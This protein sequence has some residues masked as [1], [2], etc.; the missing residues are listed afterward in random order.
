MGR[1]VRTLVAWCPDWPVTAAGFEADAP[2]A[3]TAA[4][5]VVA[6]SAAAREAG[7]VIGMRR[8][9]AEAS[10]AGLCVVPRDEAREARAFEPVVA[11]V[12]ALAPAVETTRPGLLS[13]ATRGPARYHGGEG[14]LRAA[15]AERM[16]TAVTAACGV[17]TPVHVGIADGPFAAT[18]AARRQMSVPSS[19][20]AKFL[21]PFPVGTLGREGLAEILVRLGIGSL[22]AFAALD[23]DRVS[24]RF[25]PDGA[26]AH[27]L[28]RGLDDRPL[29]ST[30]PPTEL[31]AEAE[32]DPPT[33]RVDVV[34]FA[35]RSL[36]EELA[37]Q[38]AT[39]G[40]ACTMLTIEAETEHGERL[41][42]RWRAEVDLDAPA[43]GERLRWQLEGWLS[44]TA[45]EAPSAGVTRIRFR[46]SETAPALGRQAGFWGGVSAADRRA[47]RA[48]DRLGGM[49]G[50]EAVFTA[51]V[52]GGR[53]PGDRT[54]L[55]AWG[56][57]RPEAAMTAPWPGA[58]PDPP[59][60]LV[61]RPPRRATVTDR[62]GRPV[63]VSARGCLS[64]LPER[65]LVEGRRPSAVVG[66]AGPWLLDERWWDPRVGRRLARFQLLDEDRHA[67]LCFVER[68]EWFVEATYD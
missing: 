9:A 20:T 6:C 32:L 10:C 18:L 53:G 33:E 62:T 4:N 25:G 1:I 51:T 49:L 40:L 48:L 3:V 28:A 39:R 66:W 12:A 67:H 55:V 38:L 22:G 50:P 36:G 30:P 8:R 60:A 11:A 16:A 63:V 56:D 43:M 17:P 54:A 31:V 61:H 41:A 68:A 29:R 58:L 44:G 15:V 64:G 65:I 19:G 42:R 2:V 27:R 21:A 13:M 14:P 26:L 52:V 57:T 37:A 35:G 5:R 23:E 7:V 45:A 47:A 34:A 24:A 46:A 59:P